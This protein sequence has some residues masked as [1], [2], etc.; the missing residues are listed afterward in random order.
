MKEKTEKTLLPLALTAIIL[1]ATTVLFYGIVAWSFYWVMIIDLTGQKISKLWN[2]SE[3][4]IAVLI[5]L[6]I[7]DVIFDVWL[8]RRIWRRIKEK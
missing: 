1:L 7:A 2:L 3:S 4:E 8:G 5:I 6:L